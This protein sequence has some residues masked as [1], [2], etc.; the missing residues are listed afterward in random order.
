M[1]RI[2][3]I[4]GIPALVAYFLGGWIDT[5]YH[6]KPYGTL[7]V[8][9]VA[10]VLSWTLTIRMYFKIDKAFRELRQKQ[11]MQEKE[12]KATKKNEQQ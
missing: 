12:E 2:L 4:F 11:E 9:G 10:F 5:T 6:M 7:A 8:L 1:F 3:L